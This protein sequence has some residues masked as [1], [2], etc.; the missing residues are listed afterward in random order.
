MQKPGLKNVWFPG[1]L[2]FWGGGAGS[3]GVTKASP[4]GMSQGGP[5]I[6]EA[7]VDLPSPLPPLPLPSLCG[8]S[9]AT[10]ETWFSVP[11]Y[12]GFLLQVQ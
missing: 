4:E 8:E 3:Q 12:V 5:S 6:S 11:L 1:L 7:I 10:T 2:G 9:E